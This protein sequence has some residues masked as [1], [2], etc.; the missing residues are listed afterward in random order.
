M[1]AVKE[2]NDLLTSVQINTNSIWY[3]RITNYTSQWKVQ[4]KTCDFN[5]N[6]AQ[7]EWFYEM[8]QTNY[9]QH[10]DQNWSD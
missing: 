10:N 2:R 5:L 3:Y 8:P 4:S 6:I 7:T 9:K 1:G